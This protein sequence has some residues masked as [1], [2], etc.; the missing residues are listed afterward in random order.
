MNRISHFILALA[1]IITF[2]GCS[3]ATD[4]KSSAPVPAIAAPPKQPFDPHA[5]RV[6]VPSK[7][8]TL[9]ADW[10]P[11]APTRSQIAHVAARVEPPQH[12]GAPTRNVSLHPSDD[13]VRSVS[14]MVEPLRPVPGT[15]TSEE[16][17]ALAAALRTEW[18]DRHRTLALEHFLETYPT[19][20]WAAALHVNLGRESYEKGYFQSALDHWKAAW[21]GARDGK[22]QVSTS[23]ANLALADY[24]KMNARIGR[25]DVL[26]GLLAEAQ[27]RTLTDDARNKIGSAAEGLWM[28][29][30]RPGESFRCGPLAVLSVAR[31][32]KINLGK[33]T[34][35]FLAKNQS[36]SKGFSIPDVQRMSTELGLNL[37]VAKREVGA[38]VITP[39]VVHWKVGH[40]GAVIL[41]RDG[42][43]LL[44]DPTF[45]EDLWVTADA[46]DHEASGYFLVPSGTLPTG[47][48]PATLK[49]TASLRGKGAVGLIGNG[50]TSKADHQVGGACQSDRSSLAMA[51]Y[52]IHTLAASVHIEDTPIQ[53]HPAYGPDLSIEVG[54]NQREADQP[55]TMAYTNFGPHTVSNW[56]SYTRHDDHIFMS[57]VGGGSVAVQDLVIPG[58]FPGDPMSGELIGPKTSGSPG[59]QLTRR[60]G[61]VDY[62]EQ[63]VGD[64][65]DG[66]PNVYLSRRLTPDGQQATI[67]YD[68]TLPSRIHQIIDATGLPTVF[69]T[70]I[71]VSPTS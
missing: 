25:M 47:W 49:E 18:R 31:A 24:A 42:K 51:T 67:E 44:K 55:E 37:R 62:Y 19:S 54:Y 5:T 61:G 14:F 35:A 13:E 43:Y 9:A 71:R 28:M 11:P 15:S 10:Q 59:F 53:Y 46:L 30:N 63:S 38:P 57:E 29:R 52:R 70:I 26:E 23:F 20:R 16:T 41:E 56:I 68:T 66:P 65:D 6:P 58:V 33:K 34:E 69:T 12:W 2:A 39:A 45:A 50:R 40:F 36:P 1:T 3:G 27:K 17:D 7:S 60:D 64:P 22:D 21:E 4:S 8:L 32:K 48:S